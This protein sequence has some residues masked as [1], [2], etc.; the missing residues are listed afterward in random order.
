MN[1]T[2]LERRPRASFIA[3]MFGNTAA[4]VFWIGQIF[5]GYG[6][7][8]LACYGSDHPTSLASGAALRSALYVF[9]G[10]AIAAAL[11][12]GIVSFLCLRAVRHPGTDTRFAAKITESRMRFMAF[13]GLLSSLWFLGAIVF[14]TIGTATVHLCTFGNM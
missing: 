9:D 5:L 14:T 8:S 4:P 12:G 13:W 2:G 3:L 7:T 6:V 10:I 11:A 1:T